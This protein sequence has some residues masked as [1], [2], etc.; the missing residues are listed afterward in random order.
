MG[1]DGDPCRHQG[2]P[3]WLHSSALEKVRNIR[4]GRQN[5]RRR[6][7]GQPQAVSTPLGNPDTRPRI[8]QYDEESD[9]LW[10]GNGGPVPNGMD[11]FDGCVVFSNVDRRINGIMIEDARELLLGALLGKGKNGAPTPEKAKDVSRTDEA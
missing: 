6:K 8:I 5:A 2:S 7:Q 1:A 11:V 10:M 9:T 3:S 4:G